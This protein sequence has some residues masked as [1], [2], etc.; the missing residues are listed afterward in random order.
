MEYRDVYMRSMTVFKDHNLWVLQYEGDLKVNVKLKSF[1]NYEK[2]EEWL[3]E[4]GKRI[5]EDFTRLTGEPC[6]FYIVGEYFDDESLDNI[7]YLLH[8]KHD[9]SII[10]TLPTYAFTETAY[11]MIFNENLIFISQ[12]Y[13]NPIPKHYAYVNE[14]EIK[15]GI[16]KDKFNKVLEFVKNEDKDEFIE[17]FKYYDA[18]TKEEKR[19]MFLD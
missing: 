3:I 8:N 13:G 2:A 4:N 18:K 9:L 10:P 1:E 11:D 17:E 6:V 7:E 19:N 12:D 14:N 15:Y 16:N 5:T